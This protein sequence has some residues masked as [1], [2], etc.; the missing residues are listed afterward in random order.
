MVNWRKASGRQERTESA[1]RPVRFGK[2]E[3]VNARSLEQVMRY[4]EQRIRELERRIK[5]LEGA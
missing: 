4:F 1:G 5:V 3:D 2:D